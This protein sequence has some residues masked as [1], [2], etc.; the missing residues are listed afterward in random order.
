[1]RLIRFIGF[2][3]I[4]LLLTSLSFANSVYPLDSAKK[5]PGDLPPDMKVIFLM[6]L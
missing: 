1:M 3:L 6:P 4:S 5:E 2:G